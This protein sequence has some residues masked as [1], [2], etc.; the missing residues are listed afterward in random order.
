VTW[1]RCAT[2]LEARGA[3]AVRSGCRRRRLRFPHCWARRPDTW[4]QCI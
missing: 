4:S 1:W 2:E 3:A